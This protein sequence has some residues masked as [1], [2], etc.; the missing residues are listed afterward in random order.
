[1]E[2]FEFSLLAAPTGVLLAVVA[3]VRFRSGWSILA[4]L[5][6]GLMGGFFGRWAWEW[7]AP[8]SI[9]FEHGTVDTCESG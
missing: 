5:L 7:F 9:G 8:K 2:L 3:A 4:A 6:R 1:M